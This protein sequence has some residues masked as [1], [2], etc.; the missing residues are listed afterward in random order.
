M[1]LNLCTWV[2]V[3]IDGHDEFVMTTCFSVT[4]LF[5]SMEK[6]WFLFGLIFPVKLL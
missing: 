1:F 3:L 4:K 6:T 2:V 5:S